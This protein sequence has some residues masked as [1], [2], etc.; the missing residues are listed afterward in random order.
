MRSLIFGPMPLNA[1]PDSH[2]AAGPWCFA[3]REDIFPG[4]DGPLPGKRPAAAPSGPE[5]GPE[6]GPESGRVSSQPRS[7]APEQTQ[8]QAVSGAAF[9]LPP[10]PF[11]DARALDEAARA[12]NATALRLCREAGAQNK[13]P[14]AGLAL[15]EASRQLLYGPYFLLAA[16]VLIERQ[17][18][19][20]DLLNLYG[21]EA[22]R[23]PLP[24]ASG[25]FF[26]ENSRDFML[27]GVLDPG[28]NH[29]IYARML[30]SMAPRAWRL[31]IEAAPPPGSP[32]RALAGAAP[33][34]RLRAFLAARLRDLPFP[35][36]KGFSLAQAL[37][38]SL[39]VLGNKR[40]KADASLDFSL[41]C[42]Q[43][44]PWHFDADRLILDCLPQAL[45]QP[46]RKA[47]HQ[48]L[49]Q[50]PHLSPRLTPQ[51][52]P[53]G[54]SPSAKAGPGP[55]SRPGT[56][57]GM[58]PAFMEDDSYRLRLALMLARG[59]RLFAVQHGANYGNLQSVG[60]LPFEYS[61][62]AFFTWGWQK[63]QGLPVNARPLPHPLLLRMAG[64]HQEREATLLLVGTEMSALSY[65]LKSRPQA[66]SLPDYRRDKIVFLRS[67]AE[68]LAANEEKARLLYRPYPAAPGALDDAPFMER[69]L[70]G[71][72]I[73]RGNL[74]QSL[75]RCRLLVLDHYGTTLHQALAADVPLI[76]FWKR[77][78]WTME[79]ESQRALDKLRDA[80]MLFDGPEEA[81]ATALELWPKVNS[82][83]QEPKRRAA[84]AFWL[85]RYARLS[86]DQGRPLSMAALTRLWA[87]T[88]LAT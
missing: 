3:G 5:P 65:R 40:Q 50:S 47:L 81:A 18:R 25:P 63:H 55:C 14:A 68:G 61:R 79:E 70:P 23:V 51:L 80:G 86:D 59:C 24:P 84:R 7:Q 17:Q 36:Y 20:L 1:H 19:L 85:E 60:I 64:R 41:Y 87:R 4:W 27:R 11:A 48:P 53:D 52:S 82:W 75:L 31:E 34:A 57:R 83:W 30:E 39:A 9:P 2:I 74:E 6:P 58:T 66:G 49:R 42:G 45:R 62:H 8:D 33:G 13:G 29:I 67:M 10:D 38:L 37:F 54:I 56:L 26:F 43:E 78:A 76:A 77:Q 28:F 88:L 16:Q 73:C 12:A 71:T 69:A 15:P 72:E 21:K 22:L 32:D 35:R 44:R 46:L